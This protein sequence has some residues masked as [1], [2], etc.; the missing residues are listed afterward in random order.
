[1]P[2]TRSYSQFIA[3]APDKLWVVL[4]DPRLLPQWHSGFRTVTLDAPTADSAAV[5]QHGSFD[6][7]RPFLAAGH[8]RLAP[9]F[10]ITEVTPGRHLQL[11][12][13][14]PVGS[15]VIDFVLEPTDGGCFVRETVTATAGSNCVA[16]TVLSVVPHLTDRADFARLARLAGL[17]PGSEALT[18]VLAGGS[19]ALG[20]HL[21]ADLA[22]R[23][24]HPVVLTR[25]TD[26]SSPFEQLEWDAHTVGPWA[27]RIV[28]PGRVAVVNL[29]G[30]LVD[31]RPTPRNVAALRESRT[32]A[33]RALVAAAATRSTPVAHWLQASTTAIWSDAGETWCTETTPV[34]DDGLPQMTGVARPWEESVSGAH[35]DHLVILRTSI[36]L[37]GQAPAMRRLTDL[38]RLGL[39]GSVGS[40][41]Q[42]FSWIHV[43]DWLAVARGA[44]GLDGAVTLPSGVLV[45]ASPHPVRNRELMASLRRAVHRPAAPPTPAVL[46]KIGAVALRTDPALGLTGRRAR[47][48]VLDDG[49]F[50]FR[51]PTLDSAL[52]DLLPS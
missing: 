35:T 24:Q 13:P 20:R 2:S 52:A 32:Q 23:G 11:T 47:S 30:K 6:P 39:G 48:Q 25:R 22:C 44:L 5:G 42:W 16:R 37:D 3:L 45:G 12:Q 17:Q 38:A 27:D 15:A 46:L 33:T 31:C 21:G 36:V 29:A 43:D 41:R 50:R 19:G 1:M 34:P 7:S 51:F 18:V 28:D 49:G 9:P 10:T 4:G 8:R 26:R 40:G 14:E